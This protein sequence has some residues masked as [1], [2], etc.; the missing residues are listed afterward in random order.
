MQINKNVEFTI[1]IYL[2]KASNLR[3]V[4]EMLISFDYP[5]SLNQNL[6]YKY[7]EKRKIIKSK[8]QMSKLKMFQVSLTWKRVKTTCIENESKE[9]TCK[10]CGEE[11]EW[12][13]SGKIGKDAIKSK[14]TCNGEKIGLKMFCLIV[15]N[16]FRKW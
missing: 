6:P 9:K 3:F 16:P 8:S 15:S 12:Q 14:S 13:G 7:I 2:G 1:C 4:Q 11:I 5:K 10:V